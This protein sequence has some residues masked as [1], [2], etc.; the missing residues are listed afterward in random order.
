MDIFKFAKVKNLH[1]FSDFWLQKRFYLILSKNF[2]N[3][4]LSEH[5]VSYWKN[6]LFVIIATNKKCPQKK[7]LS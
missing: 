7:K 4:V 6:K 2:L 3:L 1:F 5:N